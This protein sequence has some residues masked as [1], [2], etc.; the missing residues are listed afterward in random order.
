MSIRTRGVS[1]TKDFT[2]Y[3]VGLAHASVCTSLPLEKAIKLLNESHPTG[4]ADSEWEPSKD[5]EFASGQPNPCICEDK[6]KTHK[7]YLFSC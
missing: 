2:A 6:P 7:H 4:L 1:K 5:K 3:S